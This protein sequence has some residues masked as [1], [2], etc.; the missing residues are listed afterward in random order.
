MKNYSYIFQEEDM[1]DV[2][3]VYLVKCSEGPTNATKPHSVNI[4]IASVAPSYL[5]LVLLLLYWWM[6]SLVSWRRCFTAMIILCFQNF[7]RR[8][9]AW[10]VGCQN[11]GMPKFGHAI[12]RPPLGLL[13][14]RVHV[15]CFFYQN[16]GTFFC[17][18]FGLPKPWHAKIEGINQ[19]GPWC[20]Y[21]LDVLSFFLLCSLSNCI[22][23]FF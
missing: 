23:I 21:M 5:W 13:P 8:F 3:H 14:K 2:N 11:V 9:R 1:V 7:H 4:F 6:Y 19:W 17:L 12:L 16:S 20:L 22:N 18:D 10:L 15:S